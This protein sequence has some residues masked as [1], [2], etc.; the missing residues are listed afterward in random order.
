M[1]APTGPTVTESPASGVDAVIVPAAV[2][3]VAPVFEYRTMEFGP[4]VMV[5]ILRVVAV[6]LT[7]KAEKV[8]VWLALVLLVSPGKPVL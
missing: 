1:V 6:E 4:F 7:V 5:S 2:V 3:S 8:P